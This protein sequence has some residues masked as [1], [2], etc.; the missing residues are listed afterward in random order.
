MTASSIL[1]F[2]WCRKGLNTDYRK[3]VS[4][5][6]DWSAFSP[7]FDQAWV[8]GMELEIVCFAD[9]PAS[10]VFAT[11]V[12]TVEIASFVTSDTPTLAPVD[13]TAAKDYQLC[14]P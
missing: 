13:L 3:Y 9:P 6:D 7:L 10:L 8:V 1:A 2:D 4:Q 12:P 5:S 11:S 14:I